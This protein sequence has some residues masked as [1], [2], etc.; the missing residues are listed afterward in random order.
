MTLPIATE[1]L[2]RGPWHEIIKRRLDQMAAN[3]SQIC[4]D[5]GWQSTRLHNIVVRHQVPNAI[6]GIKLCIRL[7]LDPT[8]VFQKTDKRSPRRNARN[9]TMKVAR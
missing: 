5:L 3:Y 6:D 8:A 7:G 9:G 1:Q 4:R 2:E